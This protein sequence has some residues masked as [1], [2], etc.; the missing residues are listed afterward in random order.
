MEPCFTSLPDGLLNTLVHELDSSEVIGITLGGSYARGEA[1]RYSAIDLACFLREQSPLP[2]RR[3][4]YRGGYLLTIT[5]V[6][7]AGIRQRLSQLPDALL[8]MAEQHQ[9]L[10]DKESSVEE[11]LQEIASF[12]WASLEQEAKGYVSFQIALLA[13]QVHNILSDWLQNNR[14]ALFYTTT[15]LLLALTE[16]MAVRYGVRIKNESSYYQQVQEAVGLTSTWT[17]YHQLATGAQTQVSM[18]ERAKLVL[19]LYHE[20]VN[21]ARPLIESDHLAVAEQAVQIIDSALLFSS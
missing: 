3:Y 18:K 1:T 14:L 17:A 12:N 8:L 5:P 15:R 13:E 4:L 9:I 16:V 7:V 6:T 20:T 21:L 10:L 19:R 2:P 11:L